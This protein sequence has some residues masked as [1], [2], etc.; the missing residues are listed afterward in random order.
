MRNNVHL[1]FWLTLFISIIALIA[2]LDD[3]TIRDVY[4]IDEKSNEVTVVKY[5]IW[6]PTTGLNVSEP[7]IWIR[8]A[9]LNGHQLR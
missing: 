9:N 7:S 3:I 5:G 1:C 4:K 2:N 8:R 6:R